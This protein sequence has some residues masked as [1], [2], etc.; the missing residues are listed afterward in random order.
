MSPARTQTQVPGLPHAS[1][2]PLCLQPHVFASLPV[3]WAVPVH[4]PHCSH[5]VLPTPLSPGVGISPTLCPLPLHPVPLSKGQESK[6]WGRSQWPGPDRRV[7][8]GVGLGLT[9]LVLGLETPSSL[10]PQS[11]AR[12]PCPQGTHLPC[13][14]SLSPHT[15][16]AGGV[17]SP[18]SP[19][20]D[21][22]LGPIII[23]SSSSLASQP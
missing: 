9:E 3:F 11:P 13:R 1:E 19:R 22:L 18:V 4:P 16:P 5:Q 23:A 17:S 12:E 15:L 7:A 6:C 21:L 2:G 20:S 14:L 8:P 10:P